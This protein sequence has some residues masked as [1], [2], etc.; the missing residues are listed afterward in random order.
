MVS[1]LP[2][3]LTDFFDTLHSALP[4]HRM[5][6]VGKTLKRYARKVTPALGALSVAGVSLNASQFASLFRGQ[7]PIATL[8]NR[9]SNSLRKMDTPILVI[10]DDIDR[11]QSD[12]LVFIF[13][14]MRLIGYLPN[15]YYLIAYDETT[16]LSVITKTAAVDNREYGASEYLEKMVQVKLQMPPMDPY[17]AYDMLNTLLDE[18]KDR[19]SIA[20]SPYDEEKLNLAYTALMSHHLQEPR[21]IR[22][23]CAHL[24]APFALVRPDVDFVDYVIIAFLQFSYPSV[25]EL[26]RQHEQ[27]LTIGEA[28]ESVRADEPWSERLLKAGV[29]QDEIEDIERV[30][31]GIF[32]SVEESLGR[33][34]GLYQVEDETNHPP[35][36]GVG[37]PLYFKR[38]FSPVVAPDDLD[39]ATAREALQEILDGRPGPLWDRIIASMPINSER[40]IL[41]LYQLAPSAPATAKKLIPSLCRLAPRTPQGFERFVAPKFRLLSWMA[42]LASVLAPNER[43]G[44]VYQIVRCCNLERIASMTR[45]PSFGGHVDSLDDPP[46]S[47]GYLRVKMVPLIRDVLD[48]QTQIDQDTTRDIALLLKAWFAFVPTSEPSEWLRKRLADGACMPTYLVGIVESIG[49]LLD[50]GEP[51]S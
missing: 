25:V 15:V 18:M 33:S 51:D 17:S 3:V 27:E 44:H 24:E 28:M 32:P 41:K 6:K 11:L 7:T 4:K 5:R 2:S 23:F 10:V 39:D 50:E 29:V 36:N 13:K 21:R 14:L 30:L 46:D 45:H 26:L 42:E 43:S 49:T 16:L 9:V 31:A 37:T 34:S 20:L 8:R 19:H 1:D 22:R 40:A 38:Y 48:A 35:P 12:E 47:L